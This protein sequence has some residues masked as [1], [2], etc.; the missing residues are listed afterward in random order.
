[1]A[2]TIRRTVYRFDELSD[3]VKEKVIDRYASGNM[4]YQWW[5][6]V[7]DYAKDIGL[8]IS[9]FNIDKGYCKGLFASSAEE[10]AHKIEVDHMVSDERIAE[11]FKQNE[12]YN[13]AINYL[14]DRD[15]LINGWP[16]DE[17]GELENEGDLEDKLDDL[18][19]EFLRSL[20]EDF[21][22]ILGREYHYLTSREVIIE[23]IESNENWYTSDGVVFR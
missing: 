20:L 10:S 11:G 3:E 1:M 6:N 9:E 12:T 7:Y 17:K 13:T 8:L 18:D 14:A 15:K 5:E 4:D 16:K 21:R 22:I 23:G 2:K 19:V